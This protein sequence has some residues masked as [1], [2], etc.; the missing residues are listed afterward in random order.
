MHFSA[1]RQCNACIKKKKSPLV[2]NVPGRFFFKVVL[3]VVVVVV[4][5]VVE[6]VVAVVVTVIVVTHIEIMVLH[7]VLKIQHT[8]KASFS[9]IKPNIERKITV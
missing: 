4:V 8:V 5:T 7:Q 9:N 2:F 1:Q 6:I 3:V